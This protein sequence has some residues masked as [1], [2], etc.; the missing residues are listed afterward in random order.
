MLVLTTPSFVLAASTSSL[1]P[2]APVGADLSS[3]RFA[4]PSARA[5]ASCDGLRDQAA[6]AKCG[7]YNHY[8]EPGLATANVANNATQNSDRRQDRSHQ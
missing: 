4:M 2:C 6:T 5:R 1:M 7:D 8:L 3:G